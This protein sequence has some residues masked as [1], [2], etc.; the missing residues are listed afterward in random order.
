[1]E[2]VL[3]EAAKPYFRAQRVYGGEGLEL[4]PSFAV[5]VV[6]SGK[7]WLSGDGWEAAVAR[8]STLV[9][10]WAAGVA[11]LYGQVELL[12][13]LP[14]LPADAATDDPGREA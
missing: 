12:R 13:C 11:R 10:P 2:D 5:V 8:G 14:P 3:P 6:V 4:E 9:V 7:G 1:V